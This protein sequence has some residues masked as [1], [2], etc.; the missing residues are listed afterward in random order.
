MFSPGGVGLVAAMSPAEKPGAGGVEMPPAPWSLLVVDALVLVR[1]AVED[2]AGGGVALEPGVAALE[3][4]A[5][6]DGSDA[7]SASGVL[8]H[9]F[10]T[11][12]PTPPGPL[13]LWGSH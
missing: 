10:F 9:N 5:R 4:A 12:I 1:A 11:S 8:G 6:L 2:A 7:V 13:R 3:L